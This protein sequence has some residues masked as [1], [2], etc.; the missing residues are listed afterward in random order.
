MSLDFLISPLA[1]SLSGTRMMRIS[2]PIQIDHPAIRVF[3]VQAAWVAKLEDAVG[4]LEELVVDLMDEGQRLDL[5][6]WEEDPLEVALSVVHTNFEE[7]EQEFEA[8]V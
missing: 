8:R 4:V 5:E 3:A 2:D 6:P 7:A 1:I